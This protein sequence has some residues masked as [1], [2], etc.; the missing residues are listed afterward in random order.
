M[1]ELISNGSGYQYL[2]EDFGIISSD[3][4]LYDMQKK[5]AIYQSD[6]KWGNPILV[7][8]LKTLPKSLQREWN[9]KTKTGKNPVHYFSP[10]E[11]FGDDIAPTS[12]LDKVFYLKRVMIKGNA[13]SRPLDVDEI[14][15]RIKTASF[16][17]LKELYELLSNI[18]AVG[19][20][21]YWDSYPTIQDLESLYLSIIK[22]VLTKARC[23][24]LVLPANADPKYS[25]EHILKL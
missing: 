11:L 14:A 22:P 8:A 16:R 25:A 10:K 15:E 21:D 24:E 12:S 19:G 5:A 2:S 6:V 17:E 13:T 20:N 9:W 4:K 23:F 18:R 3:G 7:K 1:I